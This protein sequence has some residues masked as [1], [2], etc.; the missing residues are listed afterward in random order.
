MVKFKSLD[1]EKFYDAANECESGFCDKLVNQ[2]FD[3][4][5][6]KEEEVVV[7]KETFIDLMIRAGVGYLKYFRK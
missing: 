4:G 2:L 5:A 7:R 6:E 3:E 1:R